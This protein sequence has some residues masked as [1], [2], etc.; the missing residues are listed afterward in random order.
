M[1]RLAESLGQRL[2]AV[3]S[4]VAELQKRMEALDEIR[5]ILAEGRSAFK[6][7]GRCARGVR[8]VGKWTMVVIAPGIAV[9]VLIY[10]LTHNGEPPPWLEH[11]FRLMRGE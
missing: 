10:A 5:D 2:S 11:W 9:V 1:D 4:G 3:E 6:F 8:W 7:A